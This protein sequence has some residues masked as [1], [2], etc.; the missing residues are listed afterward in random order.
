[1]RYLNQKWLILIITLL[2]LSCGC[3]L[4]TNNSRVI[5]ST[6]SKLVVFKDSVEASTSIIHDDVDGF[7]NQISVIDMS[8]QM[9][10]NFEDSSNSNIK[11]QFKGFLQQEVSD[12][13]QTEKKQM[14]EVIQKAKKMLD[15][16]HVDLFP[17]DLAFIKIKTNHYGNDVYYTRGKNILIPEN[18]FSQYETEKQLPVMLHEIFHVISRYDVQK[19]ED[20][21]ALIGFEKLDKSPLLNESLAKKILTNPDGVNMNYAIRLEQDN[22]TT[23]LALPIISSKFSK[24]KDNVQTFFEYLDFDIYA[25]NQRDGKWTVLTDEKTKTTL[26]LS[27]TPSFF[28]KI[29]DNTQYIIHP[30]E[31][32]ADNFML[33]VLAHHKNDFR[34]F[35][36]EGKNL[37]YQV[38]SILKK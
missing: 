34:K 25:L 12:W 22:K 32:M 24:Y 26:P 17:S 30:D 35:S 37:I 7:F 11:E 8:I 19:R 29:K 3:K 18:I 1:M 14:N 23:I 38:L 33:A 16:I 28:T 5:E 36:P 9:K 20:L 13:K 4:I 31:I 10:K 15:S 21:Y 2:Y 27:A 6:T